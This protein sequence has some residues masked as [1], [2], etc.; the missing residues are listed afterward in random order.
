MRNIT[1]LLM[2]LLLLACGIKPEL[3]NQIPNTEV[4]SEDDYVIQYRWL[5]DG[6][7]DLH[8]SSTSRIF[9]AI[10]N[11]SLNIFPA[12]TRKDSVSIEGWCKFLGLEEPVYLADGRDYAA[13]LWVYDAADGNVKGFDGSLFAVDS[14]DVEL[15]F[16]DDWEDVVAVCADTDGHVFV[17]DRGTNLIYRYHVSGSA[18]NPDVDEDGFLSW[19]S[20]GGGAT[21]RDMAYADGNIVLLTTAPDGSSSE[22]LLMLQILDPVNGPQG[23][24]EYFDDLLGDPRSISADGDHLF[25]TDYADTSLWEIGW[26]LLPSEANR[27][28]SDEKVQL[29]NPVSFTINE[30]RVY[31]ADPELGMIVDYEKRQ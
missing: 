29:L 3:P 8:L 5:L 2:L 18:G 13:H 1:I 20:Q 6:V 19:T 23:E 24:F 25:V 10:H 16:T 12:Y 27:V 21:V 26:D 11:D 15:S 28:N 4:F 22:N 14:L 7:A 17:A 9:Y 31:V 30:G